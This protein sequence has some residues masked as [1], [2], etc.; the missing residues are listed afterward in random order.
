MLDHADRYGAASGHFGEQ[1]GFRFCLGLCLWHNAPEVACAF[2]RLRRSSGKCLLQLSYVYLVRVQS[3]LDLRSGKVLE[4]ESA[5]G[6]GAAE[7]DGDV[8]QRSRVL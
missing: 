1:T 3:E 2:S 6:I 5:A 7:R 8:L 4:R